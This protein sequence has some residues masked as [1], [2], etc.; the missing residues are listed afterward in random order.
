MAV[1]APLAVFGII[2]AQGPKSPQD[3][4]ILGSIFILVAILDILIGWGV[5]WLFKGESP[6]LAELS[7]WF[8]MLYGVILLLSTAPLFIATTDPASIALTDTAIA[9]FQW[10]WDIG[11]FLF[12]LHL[13]LLGIL[14][15]RSPN[16]GRILGVL[17][18]VSGLAYAIDS[19]MIFLGIAFPIVLGEY[20]FF[21]EILF[22]VWLFYR[23]F[24]GM[25]V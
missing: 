7:S 17:V 24:K 8:R 20:F 18:L 22:M 15:Y 5:H 6:A 21:G 19:T 2:E 16:F 12:G 3:L 25:K 14:V 11:L 10:I 9:N 1:L 23:A 4:Q 13:L